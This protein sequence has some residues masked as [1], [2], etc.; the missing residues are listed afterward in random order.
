MLITVETAAPAEPT[1]QLC[2]TNSGQAAT[3][4]HT[5]IYRRAELLAHFHTKVVKIVTR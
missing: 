4:V 5:V 3:A 1:V 2:P